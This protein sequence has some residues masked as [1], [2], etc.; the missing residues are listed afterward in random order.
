MEVQTVSHEFRMFTVQTVQTDAVYSMAD[1]N[2]YNILHWL[3]S[4]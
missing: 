1:S 4:L 3:H 2:K